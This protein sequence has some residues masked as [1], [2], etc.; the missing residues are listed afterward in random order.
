MRT[1]LSDK[2]I[3]RRIFQA[4][5]ETM[6]EV[7]EELAKLDSIAGDGDH[8]AGMVRGFKAALDA[9]LD[10]DISKAVTA[11][12]KAFSNSAGGSSGA[13]VGMFIM[14]IGFKLSEEP[15]SAAHVAKGLEAGLEAIC[16]LGKAKVGDKTMIDTIAPFV[17]AYLRAAE[18]T[19]SIAEAWTIALPSA[20]LGMES[21]RNM[22][23]NRGRA[24]KLGDRS[25]GHIDP[26]A[27]SM[28]YV[29]KTVEAI[30]REERIASSLS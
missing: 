30:L 27:R 23:S 24:S 25:L 15:L 8:G 29:A 4:I 14:Q 17:V 28:Y 21:T 20:E 16:K 7:E 12:G 9:D 11:A 6:L 13:L 1:E 2:R 10:L 3:V 5:Y 19:T 22:T 18:N 26:G